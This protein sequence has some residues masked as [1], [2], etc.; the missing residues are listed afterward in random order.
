MAKNNPKIYVDTLG[1][2][3][4]DSE[5]NAT[6]GLLPKRLND[7]KRFFEN[8]NLRIPFINLDIP[9]PE[10]VNNK[11]NHLKSMLDYIRQKGW[12]NGVVPDFVTH[13]QLLQGLASTYEEQGIHV[14][15]VN[16][17]VFM[18]KNNEI[19]IP[20]TNFVSMF[21]HHLTRET[22]DEPI[23]TDGAVR[24]GVFNASIDMGDGGKRENI[25]YNG[26]IDLIDDDNQHNE[27]KVV[28]G[29]FPPDS[30]FWEEQSKR[31]YWQSFFGNSTHLLLGARTGA[32]GKYSKTRPPKRFPPL[33]VFRVHKMS[34]TKLYKGAEASL[35]KLPSKKQIDDGYEDIRSLLSLIREHVTD[36]GDGFVFSRNE[37]GGEWTIKRDDEAVAD[38]KKEILKNIPN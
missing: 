22:K 32:Y 18:Y 33:S 38:F 10:M 24:K 1:Y 36:D 2:C 20:Y 23:E 21:R 27:V 8:P 29:D 14:V 31:Y 19:K 34:L 11:E 15:K 16:G 5:F 6:P 26:K 25:L 13:K 30:Y 9:L 7:Y 28:N 35:S 37:G 4:V 17:V 3:H 12:P